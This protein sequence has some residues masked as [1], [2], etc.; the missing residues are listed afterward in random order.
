MAYDYM[1][2]ETKKATFITVF[3]ENEGRNALS[4]LGLRGLKFGERQGAPWTC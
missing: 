4:C 1:I 2:K 3:G